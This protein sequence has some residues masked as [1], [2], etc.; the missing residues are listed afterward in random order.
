MTEQE[1][2]DKIRAGDR[3]A[4]ARGITLVESRREDHRPSA[5]KLL[6]LLMPRTGK[7][8]R[9]GISGPP[10]V[11]KST[12]I[13]AF[14][15]YLID[16]GHKIAVLAIDPSS[17]ISGG[18]ILGDKTRMTELAKRKEAFIRPSPAGET[19]GG[20]ARRTREAML[21]CEAAGFDVVIVETVGVGQSETAVAEMTDMF[22]LLLSPGGG[23]DLQGV[24]RGVME[25]ADLLIVNKADGDL[26]AA[27]ERTA[28]DYAHALRLMHA[29]HAD[30]QPSVV[31][32]SALKSEGM[33]AVWDKVQ[34]FRK[35]TAKTGEFDTRRS[36]QAKNW[37]WQEVNDGLLER[38]KSDPDL[39]DRLLRLEAKVTQ[40]KAS[41]AAAAR[42]LLSS[43]FKGLDD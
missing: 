28:S 2:A 39:A 6:D 9:L 3:R 11:G 41:P 1:L 19:L 22:L 24:K 43:F 34:A 4:L 32:C 37:L 23:D 25:L 21:L 27:A 13:E 10:G 29:L 17:K 38:L 42:S 12:F 26:A 20:V 36:E 14:G 31:K 8:I 33:V 30:W 18:S 35:A 16:E 15:Q 5:E 40:R 7:S